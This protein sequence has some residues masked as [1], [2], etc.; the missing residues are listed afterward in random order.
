MMTLPHQS[1]NLLRQ[2]VHNVVWSELPSL[3]F[4]AYVLWHVL[5]DVLWVDTLIRTPKIIHR[6]Y[7]LAPCLTVGSHLSNLP[8]MMIFID[9]L[10]GIKWKVFL[11][12]IQ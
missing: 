10:M 8:E 6:Y 11:L 7:S 1:K 12:C 5:W 2:N 4:V 3:Y 9:I